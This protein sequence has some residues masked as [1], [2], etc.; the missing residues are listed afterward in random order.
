MNKIFRRSITV[1]MLAAILVGLVG[2]FLFEYATKAPFWATQVRNPHLYTRGILDNLRITDRNGTLLF[3]S[4]NGEITLH[5]DSLVR[6]S[7]L[8]AI[9]DLNGSIGSGVL[10]RYR[11]KL[12]DFGFA[13][14]VYGYKSGVHTLLLHLD[15]QLCVTAKQ[16]LGNYSGTVGLMNYLT[17]EIYAM[18]STPDFDPIGSEINAKEGAYINRFLSSV[19]TPGSI[20]KIVTLQAAIEN[21]ADLNDMTFTCDGDCEIGGE[22]ITCAGVHGKQTIEQ[23]FANSCN[24]AFG[25]L[26]VLIGAEKLLACANRVGIL[27]SATVDDYQTAKGSIPIDTALDADLAWAGI[28]QYLDT[29]NPAAFLRYVSAI[30]NKGVAQDLKLCGSVAVGDKVQTPRQGK[31]QQ[32]M[33]A[34]TAEKLTEYM[35]NN[36][37]SQYGQWRFG[38]IPVC[39]KSGTA[40]QD[41]AKAHSVFTGFVADENLPIAFFVIAENAGAGQGVALQVAAKLIKKANEIIT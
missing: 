4:E 5:E 33:S 6:Q 23:A 37:S 20:M 9:G 14:G 11:E 13:T 28:G 31:T 18:V 35:R 3:S 8:H 19:Y 21:I 36:V 7:V 27:S 17:G 30:A 1:L 32:I 40:Q 38:D 41:H 2:F 15:A 39:A 22:V 26:S 34:Q 12:I 25:E 29:V 24:C 10:Y 16:A